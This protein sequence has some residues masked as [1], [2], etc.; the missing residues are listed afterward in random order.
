MTMPKK[1]DE[2]ALMRAVLD[3]HHRFEVR[4]D[5]QDL[6]GRFQHPRAWRRLGMHP[7]RVEHIDQKWFRRGWIEDLNPGQ[8]CLTWA[9]VAALLEHV[10]DWTPPTDFLP[11]PVHGP[12]TQF[13]QIM[14]DYTEN[15]QQEMF[16]QMSDQILYGARGRPASAIDPSQGDDWLVVNK[17]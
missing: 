11:L 5:W 16:E 7:K 1:P 13:S 3:D 6:Q 15:V 2:L 10:P 8:M 14:F 12:R 4:K 17:P 9:G